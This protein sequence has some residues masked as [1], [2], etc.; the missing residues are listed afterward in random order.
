MDGVLPI[1]LPGHLFSPTLRDG[2][3]P[4]EPARYV[5]CSIE[6][7]TSWCR[8]QDEKVEGRG[9]PRL[10]SGM[11]LKYLD[12]CLLKLTWF[13]EEMDCCLPVPGSSTDSC[14]GHG[15]NRCRESLLRYL[16]QAI[17]RTHLGRQ[18]H[19]IYSSTT[20][21]IVPQMVILSNVSVSIAVTSVLF[22]Y[23]VLKNHLAHHRPLAKLA[24][25]KA[26][27]FLV[28]IQ[29]VGASQLVPTLHMSLTDI[30][31]HL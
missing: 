24:A 31:L 10:V 27:I 13:I 29:G 20:K 30:S 25:F 15:C 2:F 7:S 9:G 16:D 23:Q 1:H 21:L 3:S 19:L 28:F 17:L 8:Q 14:C 26:V 11:S 12:Q 4:R 18:A 6:R 22:F 5:F